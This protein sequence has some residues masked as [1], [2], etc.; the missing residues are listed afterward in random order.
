[1]AWFNDQ[2]VECRQV[3]SDNG[4]AY[5]S[6]SLAKACKTLGTKHIRTKPYT[7]RTNRMAE[8]HIQILCK[9]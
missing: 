9:E 8:R 3:M 5:L 6:R 4:P 7:P 1:V 2:G